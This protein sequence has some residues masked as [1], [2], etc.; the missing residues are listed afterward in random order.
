MRSSASSAFAT[1]AKARTIAFERGKQALQRRL[2]VAVRKR[3][4][5]GMGLQHA[6]V[7]QHRRHQPQ[8]APELVAIDLVAPSARAQRDAAGLDACAAVPSIDTAAC[9]AST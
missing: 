6:E 9:R 2:Q 1:A 7:A 8:A 4:V 5:L 3:P